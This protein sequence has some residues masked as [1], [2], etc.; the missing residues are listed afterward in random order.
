MFLWSLVS[1]CTAAEPSITVAQP[2][3]DL[4]YSESS[5]PPSTAGILLRFGELRTPAEVVERPFAEPAPGCMETNFYCDLFL[6]GAA[7]SD[8]RISPVQCVSPVLPA[9]FDRIPEVASQKK[10]FP[11]TTFTPH[12]RW[13]AD[14]E[15]DAAPETLT[16]VEHK[17]PRPVGEEPGPYDDDE[18]NRQWWLIVETPTGASVL[19]TSDY[20]FAITN[21]FR[22]KG[23]LYI[24]FWNGSGGAWDRYAVPW[25]PS[26]KPTALCGGNG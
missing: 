11:T 13:L 15:G 20:G 8:V 23:K 9:G 2:D 14:V 24:D 21:I 6:Q 25:P 10:A 3:P 12:R 22:L 16:A 19:G 17:W 26:G 4:H 1:L 18:W 7:A 5:P